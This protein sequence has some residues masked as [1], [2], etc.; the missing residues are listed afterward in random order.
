MFI[1]LVACL[2][3]LC[4]AAAASCS[5]GY[6]L[7]DAA[8]K[9]SSWLFTDVMESD[10]TLRPPALQDMGWTPQRFNV[11][12]K[13]GRGRYGK[14]FLPENVVLQKTD[15]ARSE[16]DIGLELRVDSKRDAWGAITAAEVDTSRTDM[17]WGS[18]RVGMKL[19]RVTGTCAAFFWVCAFTHDIYKNIGKCKLI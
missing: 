19:T 14:S 16:S 5:C 12:A 13:T 18:Y 7:T 6:L 9:R 10:F 1:F 3:V 8:G 11:S 4:C 15:A 2:H 17:A